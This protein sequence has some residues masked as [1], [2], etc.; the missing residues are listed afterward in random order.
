[1]LRV[2]DVDLSDMNWSWGRDGKYL[3]HDGEIRCFAIAFIAM[4]AVEIVF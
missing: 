1:L 4:L 3:Q 2:I